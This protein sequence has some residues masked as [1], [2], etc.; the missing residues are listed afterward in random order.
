MSGVFHKP[1]LRDF[2]AELKRKCDPQDSMTEREIQFAIYDTC[3][4]W[5]EKLRD[6]RV[7]A[8]PMK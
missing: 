4:E 7:H 6:Y 8:R 5:L 1:K 2:I 3:G